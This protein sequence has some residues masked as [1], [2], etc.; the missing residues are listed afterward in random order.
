MFGVSLYNWANVEFN[1]GPVFKYPVDGEVQPYQTARVE[2]H[3][4]K[5]LKF[6]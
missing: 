5:D 2:T 4:Y 1:E 6:D 3:R